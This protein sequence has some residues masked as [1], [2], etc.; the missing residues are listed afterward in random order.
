MSKI[1]SE[2]PPEEEPR[3]MSAISDMFWDVDLHFCVQAIARNWPDGTTA[4]VVRAPPAR[5]GAPARS[6]RSRS[7]RVLVGPDTLLQRA[8]TLRH[9][10]RP[11]P[12]P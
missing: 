6:L 5:F 10:W 8:F 7:D 12:C 9:S 11:H 4:C 1:L 3:L 2:V